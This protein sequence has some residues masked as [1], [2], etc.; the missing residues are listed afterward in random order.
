MA[1]EG[2]QA[3]PPGDRWARARRLIAM[4]GDERRAIPILLDNAWLLSPPTCPDLDEPIA[5]AKARA[6][7]MRAHNVRALLLIY[8]DQLERGEI[9]ERVCRFFAEQAELR[10]WRR[11]DPVVAMRD[12]LGPPKRGSPTRNAMRDFELASEIQEISDGE[13]KTVEEACFEVWERLQDTP[14][15]LD[16]R[17]LRR[18]YFRQSGGGRVNKRAVR[19]WVRVRALKQVE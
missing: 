11:D 1:K 4:L 12:F 2:P 17:S 10:I 7:R 19:A 9:D 8:R 6:E 16:P 18:I 13:S 3:F 5:V 14:Q 15:E